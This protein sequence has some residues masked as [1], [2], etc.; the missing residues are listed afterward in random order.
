MTEDNERFN[1]IEKH[2]TEL[3]ISSADGSYAEEALIKI[4]DKYGI[5][6]HEIYKSFV[7]KY[8]HSTFEKDV[9]Y[10]PIE[11]SHWTDKDGLNAFGS[12]F[13]FDE[14]VDNLERKI[15][16]YYDRIPA[17]IVPIA[18]DYAGNLICIGISGDREG[19]IYFWDHENEITARVMLGEKEYESVSVDDYWENI[20]VIADSFFDFIKSFELEKRTTST[21][22]ASIVNVKMSESFLEMLE[23][24]EKD[25]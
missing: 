4:E 14:G 16:Q 13:G 7:C 18:E 19:K 12:F 22:G 1:K 24:A 25:E 21:S 2:V 20:Y 8:G 6:F 11:P 5:N 17:S 10:R 15:Q 9:C 23:G 3:F